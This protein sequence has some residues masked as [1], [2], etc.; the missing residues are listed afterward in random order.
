MS[1]HTTVR[2][3][4][5]M[6]ALFLIL[7]FAVVGVLWLIPGADR[8]PTGQQGVTGQTGV[9]GATGDQGVKGAKGAKGDTGATGEKG[10]KGAGFWGVS[11]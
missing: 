8:G 7:L 11:K 9:T 2:V 1:A 6:L 3:F 4:K 10:A 5:M